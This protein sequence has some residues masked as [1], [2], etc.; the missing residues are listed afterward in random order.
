[1]ADSAEN[2][3]LL[4]GQYLG[5]DKVKLVGLTAV[6]IVSA[7]VG[8]TTRESIRLTRKWEAIPDRYR[9]S[10]EAVLRART[11]ETDPVA[12]GETRTGRWKVLRVYSSSTKT[13]MGEQGIFET[14]LYWPESYGA[15]GDY[16]AESGVLHHEDAQVF[17]DSP[18]PADCAH[19]LTA[20]VVYTASNR[21]DPETGLWNGELR[22]DIARTPD[23]VVWTDGGPLAT[24][25]HTEQA[26]AEAV[27]TIGAGAAGTNV[28][29]R[30]DLNRF[31]R[32]DWN[33]V[34]E[35][36]VTPAAVSW[37][38]GGPLVSSDHTE[39][40]NAVAV[41]TIGAGTAGTNVSGRV[42]LNRFGRFDWNKTIETAQTPAAITWETGGVLEK[43]ARTRQMNAVAV[44]TIAAGA[45]GTLVSG[46]IDLNRFGRFDW[47]KAEEVAQ[48][49][50]VIGW[51]DGG[52]LVSTA[53]ARQ[54]NDTA[55]PTIAAGAAGSNTSASVDLNRFGR[56]DWTTATETAQTP[57]AITWTDGGPLFST[58]HVRQLNAAA[59]PTI[60]AGAAGSN[61]SASVDLN[62]FGRFDW[63]TATETAVAVSQTWTETS[64]FERT[65]GLT[66]ENQETVPAAP[67][68]QGAGT[69]IV[70]MQVSI[71]RF[72]RFDGAASST[73]ATTAFSTGS[74]TL[75]DTY[76]R[77]TDRKWYFNQTTAP[78]SA[79]KSVSG[80]EVTIKTYDGTDFNRFGLWDYA[81]TTT[82]L[83][84]G[85]SASSYVLYG[86]IY[87]IRTENDTMVL[88]QRY[89]DRYT[90]AI[91]IH[92]TRKA[93]QDAINGKLTGSGVSGIGAGLW[94][95]D[96]VTVDDEF[97]N[98][99]AVNK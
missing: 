73:S 81:E 40:M 43:T 31:G 94:I 58:A 19:L 24:A 93:A 76:E 64:I 13:A 37:T 5:N 46:S 26:N 87:T 14:L 80:G 61:T 42:D 27:P 97:L 44:P 1:M 34:I 69:P 92:T 47:D 2:R 22:T 95:S 67:A 57:S 33:K 49:P 17:F 29:G 86:Q 28:S 74:I 84:T 39:Q 60:A 78:T 10:L 59:G 98:Q 12:D 71:N 88:Y 52:P 83:R 50:T 3:A 20:G 6:K 70:K 68:A 85:A 56:F 63:T 8:G 99:V 7:A 25:E 32:F 77:K 82:T 53:H 54:M 72:G 79:S 23:P 9:E 35:T 65:D 15:F 55:G 75:E 16:C 30:V 91:G 48:K 38:D 90:H 62:R 66:F 11:Y 96:G 21:I 89:R 41:P 4:A 51:T 18:V 45:A 36:A